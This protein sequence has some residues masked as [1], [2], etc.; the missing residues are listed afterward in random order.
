M[1]RAIYYC[2]QCS[3]R[4]SDSDI[5]SGKAYRVGDRILCAPCAPESVK[6][7]TSKR[8]PAVPRSKGGSTSINPKVPPP[9]PPAHAPSIP[10]IRMLV[11]G[12]LLAVLLVLGAI[13]LL[14]RNNDDVRETEKSIPVVV[15]NSGNTPKTPDSL[16]LSARADLAKARDF[17]RA[18]PDDWT[19]RLK[20]F[21]GLARKWEGT[22]AGREAATE[23]AA[24]KA[25][26]PE[27]MNGWM[28][29]AEAKI[30]ELLKSNQYAAAS[31]QLEDLKSS[32]D[33]PEWRQALDT[34]ASEL[35]ALARKR[36]EEEATKKKADDRTPA[37]ALTEEARSQLV[38]W[39]AAAAKATARDYAGAIADLERSL[40]GLKE[41]DLKAEA[42]SD[43]ALLRKVAAAVQE[44]IDAL[45]RRPRG[46]ALSVQ[47]RDAAGGL[48]RVSGAILQADAERMELRAGRDSVFVDWIEVAATTL[49]DLAQKG[50]FDPRALAALCLLEGEREA[51]VVFGAELPPKWWTYADGARAR[52]PKPDPV[53]RSARDLFAAA[54][55]GYRSM[56]TRTAAIE[57]YRSLRANFG[58]TALAKTY[59][60]RITRRSE[61]GKEYYVTPS[62]FRTE[63]TLRLAKSGR[64]E[65]S[66]DSEDR[67]TLLNFAELEFAALPGQPYR[68]WIWVGAC[69]EETF[70]FYTQGSELTDTDPKTKKKVAVEPGSGFAVPVKHSIRNLKKTHADHKP[71]G[72]AQHPKTASR[73]EWVEVTLPR[74]AAPGAKKLRFMTNQAGFS[75]G[76]VF[77]SAVRKAPP[78]ESELK[79]LEKARALDE[80]PLPVDPDLIGWWTFDDKGESST[81]DATGNGHSGKFVGEVKRVEGKIGGAIE[82]AGGTSGVEIAD[83]AEFRIPGDVTLAIWVRKSVEVSDWNCVM[84]RGTWE[85]RNYGLWLEPGSRKY[86]FQQYGNNGADSSISFYGTKLV[87]LGKWTHLAVTVE[88]D[89]VRLYYNGELDGQT[90]RTIVPWTSSAPLGLGYAMMHSAFRGALDDA[91]LYKRALSPAEIRALADVG[92]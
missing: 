84:G 37:P 45:R 8:M 20:E 41:A 73:W 82:V 25:G 36:A 49:A 39:E 40:A 79:D 3:Q 48:K 43:V 68:G 59:T 34:R 44:A 75:I 7:V 11:L 74:Y 42:E 85:H 86:M 64:I 63:G 29:E 72:A 88:Q 87:D 4:V 54:E 71:K 33:I 19:G 77:V 30:A 38:R 27:K 32:H 1:G 12:G 62:D 15:P 21:R 22:E 6:S 47:V 57:R 18:H 70:L 9:E 55:T 67:E 76:G 13:V 28:A 92:R 90:K 58:T 10:R 51:A 91:R 17:A 53:E 52:L 65:S 5:E 24:L 35:L 83:A 80:P 89:Q 50:P 46:G 23:A 26:L 2:V 14:R 78:T 69:C 66:K 56:E 61:A 60:E 16:E 31:K 81:E